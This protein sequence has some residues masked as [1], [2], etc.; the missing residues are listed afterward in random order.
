M[1]V[2]AADIEPNRRW[3]RDAPWPAALDEILPPSAAGVAA[4]VLGA[5]PGFRTTPL[6]RLDGLAHTLGI[7]EIHY[8]D[9]GR[10]LADAGLGS[11][12]AMGAPV[13]LYDALADRVAARTG[14][15][16]TAA[17]LV[18][19]RHAVDVAD[20]VAV[21]ATDGNHGRALA[22]AAACFGCACRIYVGTAVSAGRIDA[23]ARHGAEVVQVEGT[24][25]DAVLRASEDAARHG[26]LEISDTARDGYEDAPRAV[27]HGYMAMA[28][29]VADVL[30]RPPTHVFLQSG[31]G[32]FAAAVAAR[33]WQ[34]WGAKRPRAIVVEPTHAACLLASVRAGRASAVGGELDTIMAGLACGVPSTTAWRVLDEAAFAFMAIGDTP[35]VEAMRLLAT[36]DAGAGPIVAGESGAAGLAGLIV[37]RAAPALSDSLDLG[38]DSRVLL[39]GTEGATD[40]ALYARLVEAVPGGA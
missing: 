24:Y 16:P 32:G 3:R 6:H 20:A 27:M 11:F 23:I 8:K 17:D 21:S 22:W 35:A 9:E 40:P 4:G 36:G 10:R 25:D 12:K 37:A 33:F 29:E 19:S 1:I 13:A 39:F 28:D 14:A 15:K 2:A 26:W 34:R 5:L 18:S 7:A 30:D 31:V 38:P